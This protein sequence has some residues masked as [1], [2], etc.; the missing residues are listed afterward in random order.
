MAGAMGLDPIERDGKALSPIERNVPRF[1]MFADQ[2][3]QM[4]LIADMVRQVV[5]E[6]KST[7]QVIYRPIVLEKHIPCG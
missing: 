3:L 4:G 7:D 5:R 6:V 1:Q 2:A